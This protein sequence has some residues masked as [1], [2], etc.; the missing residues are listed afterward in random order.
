MNPG[1]LIAPRQLTD[2][3]VDFASVHCLTPVAVHMS[4]WLPQETSRGGL[5]VVQHVHR[6]TRPAEVTFLRVNERDK[7][8]LEH[9]HY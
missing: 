6:V 5:P 8:S 9:A 3:W 7:S 4:F 1:Q 2:P